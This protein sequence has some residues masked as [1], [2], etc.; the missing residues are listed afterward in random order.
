MLCRGVQSLHPSVVSNKYVRLLSYPSRFPDTRR[1]DWVKQREP[2]S[3]S[4]VI[5][6]LDITRLTSPPRVDGIFV[7]Y[8]SGDESSFAP[9]SNFLRA[10][11]AMLWLLF[12]VAYHSLQGL[13]RP[14]KYSIIAVA[15]KSDLSVAV[16]PQASLS[17]FQQH[18]VGL[19]QVNHV[20]DV[21]KMRKA[22]K[23]LLMSILRVPSKCFD[24]VLNT[25]N[26]TVLHI[27]ID[28]DLRNPA[29]P[30][31]LVSPLSFESRGSISVTPAASSSVPSIRT[32]S[33]A[34]SFR[35]SP[36]STLP[37]SPPP[38]ATSPTRARSTSDL[39][40]EHEKARSRPSNEHKLP[41]ARSVT[42]L[43]TSN[44]LQSPSVSS[45]HPVKGD[46]LNE[47]EDDDRHVIK[48][49]E[50]WVFFL[51]TTLLSTEAIVE[52]AIGSIRHFGR[53][54]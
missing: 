33:Q 12:P 50:P 31:A 23:F 42:S 35:L 34:S 28:A 53:A 2:P 52:K 14:M 5:H 13:I 8:D 7:C 1:L 32:T 45:S 54:P 27:H 41:N 25:R 18:D 44:S 46:S 37:S 26:L 4:I 15:L 6:E 10:L 40:S 49:K 38:L 24:V 20:G 16:D 36:T 19:V 39:F 30:E 17:L 48:D 21:G 3:V 22:F 47:L 9:V 11:N 51:C 43:V 29:S